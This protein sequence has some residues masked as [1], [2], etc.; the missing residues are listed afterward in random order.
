MPRR[1]T[2]VVSKAAEIT[3]KDEGASAP[4]EKMVPDAPK[5]E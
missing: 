2:G 3:D 4:I 1:A 5:E